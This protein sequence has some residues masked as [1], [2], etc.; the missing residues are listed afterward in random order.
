MMRVYAT[1]AGSDIGTTCAYVEKQKSL[2][3]PHPYPL[4][5][6]T[7]S[8]SDAENYTD[9]AGY[10]TALLDANDEPL[11]QITGVIHVD[12][13]TSMG[14]PV[15]RFA[16]MWPGDLAD[17]HMSGYPDLP[18]GDYR[19]RVMSMSGTDS[20]EVTIKFNPVADP[21]G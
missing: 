12:E 13:T 8:M 14:G 17:V 1:G 19:M 6:T 7:L 15:H 20:D 5:E 16:S 21:T 3:I 11:M 18:D 4:R 10:A 9:L 2:Q